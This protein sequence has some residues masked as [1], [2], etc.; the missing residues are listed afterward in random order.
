M[1]SPFPGM[2]PFIESQSWEDFHSRFIHGLSDA[3]VP[4]VR[5]RYV[6]TVERRV[7]VQ[8]VA[9]EPGD[10]IRPDISVAESLKP[11]RD[12]VTETA[13]PSAKSP[14][15]ESQDVISTVCTLPMPVEARES[16]LTLR[17]SVTREVVTVIEVLSPWNKRPGIDGRREYLEKREAVLQS[18]SH[19]IELDLLRGGARLPTVEPLPA[20]DYYLIT[21]RVERRPRA[22][23]LAWRLRGKLPA[24]SVPLAR[25]EPDVRVELGEVF[26]TTYDRAGY[27]YSLDYAAKVHP[28]LSDEDAAWVAQILASA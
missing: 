8:H 15:V 17:D 10:A 23:V 13:V 6:V 20:A 26:T 28:A 14:D 5:P 21:S 9:D 22:D 19:L 11:G 16:Y 12:A 4:R 7:Y 27:D 2:D 1:P 18:R 24:F 25:G 3:L